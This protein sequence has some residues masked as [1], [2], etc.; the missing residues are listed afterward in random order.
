MS[1]TSDIFSVLLGIA[2]LGIALFI[3]WHLLRI[4]FRISVA[5]LGVAGRL[6]AWASESDFIGVALYVI[7]WVIA[8]PVM[9]VICIV[10]GIFNVLLEASLEED[11]RST[12]GSSDAPSAESPQ[13]IQP[14]GNVAASSSGLT[15]GS[16][17]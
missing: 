3:A 13:T 11:D 6:F 1:D 14:D 7:L 4:A 10:G 12:Q 5:A 9:L 15:T 17:Y 16:Q 2:V 8:F